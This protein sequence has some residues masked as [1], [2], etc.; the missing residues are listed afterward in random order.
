MLETLR[1]IGITLENV[2][3]FTTSITIMITIIIQAIKRRI[4]LEG[5]LPKY[6]AIIIGTILSSY[7]F[8]FGNIFYYSAVWYTIAFRIMLAFLISF[9]SSEF[10]ELL[11]VSSKKGTIAGIDEINEAAILSLGNKEQE[12]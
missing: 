11:K 10:Y 4:D 2:I 5:E 6:I 9:F 1:N 7:V 8:L 3:L 12:G